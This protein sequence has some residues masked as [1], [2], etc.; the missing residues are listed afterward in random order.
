MRMGLG[1]YKLLIP[2]LRS[3]INIQKIPFN[4]DKT[5][6]QSYSE[7]DIGADTGIEERNSLKCTAE[8][9]VII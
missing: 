8:E 6:S 9:E 2:K 7:N 4:N 3:D 5:I 1:S